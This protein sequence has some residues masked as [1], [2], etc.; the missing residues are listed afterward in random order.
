MDDLFK[1][2]ESKKIH[3]AKKD[4]KRSRPSQ[5]STSQIPTSNPTRTVTGR[6]RRVN[7][8][9]YTVKTPSNYL[10]KELKKYGFDFERYEGKNHNKRG[11]AIYLV[12]LLIEL[13]DL[14][15]E[16]FPEFVGMY[17]RELDVMIW[18]KIRLQ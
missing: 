2:S 16:R 6:V 9:K 18:K 8:G 5:P 15:R 4:G 14:K 10:R 17:K 12:L 3:K 1:N 11:T 7:H 13:K